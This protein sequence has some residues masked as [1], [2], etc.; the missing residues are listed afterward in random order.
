[1]MITLYDETKLRTGSSYSCTV[2]LV[3]P[4]HWGLVVQG[5]VEDSLDSGLNEIP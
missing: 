1:M 2:V 4:G 3:T 5:L